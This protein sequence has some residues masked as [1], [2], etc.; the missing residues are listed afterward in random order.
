MTIDILAALRAV[1]SR[2]VP[3][4]RRG[5]LLS[6][7]AKVAGGDR[8]LPSPPA[9]AADPERLGSAEKPDRSRYGLRQMIEAQVA[10]AN[11]DAACEAERR[12]PWAESWWSTTD[13]A[14]VAHCQMLWQEVL[15]QC[16]MSAI[17]VHL[18]A[19]ISSSGAT[20][21]WIG[22]PDF[23]VVC[24]L[25]GFE[26]SAVAERLRARLREPNGAEAL[27]QELA[28]APRRSGDQE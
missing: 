22:S 1:A 6:D 10:A 15:R 13:S 26:P 25:A 23:A 9:A 16:L 11:R 12:A 8:L 24:D 7:L 3:A 4:P 5:D 21:A 17:D 18:G 20:T 2:P 27:R 14:D 19:R 28:V